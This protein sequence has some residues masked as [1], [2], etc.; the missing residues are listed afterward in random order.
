MKRPKK[1]EGKGTAKKHCNEQNVHPIAEL[2]QQLKYE[3]WADLAQLC[4]A[5]ATRPTAV[6]ITEKAASQQAKDK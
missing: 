4:K 2:S 6:S 1:N 3:Q 5:K